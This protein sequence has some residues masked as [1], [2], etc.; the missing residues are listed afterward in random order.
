MAGCDDDDDDATGPDNQSEPT[1][2]PGPPTATPTGAWGYV[3]GHARVQVTGLP[4]VPDND[5]EVIFCLGNP[6]NINWVN[7]RYRPDSKYQI[8]GGLD[9]DSNCVHE[10]HVYDAQCAADG[11]WIVDWYEDGRVIVISPCGTEEIHIPGGKFAFREIVHGSCGGYIDWDS[12]ASITV[13]EL[14]GV[15]GYATEC[16]L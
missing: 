8:K 13:L 4:P 11:I 12:P 3:S 16:T 14:S 15:V 5:K 1:A 10:L 9:R 7:V 2:T 6:D